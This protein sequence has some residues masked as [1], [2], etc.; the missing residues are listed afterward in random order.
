LLSD[1]VGNCLTTNLIIEKNA[2]NGFDASSVKDVLRDFFGCQNTY[3]LPF[4]E[5]EQTGHVDMYAAFTGPKTLILGEYMVEHDPENA[6]I[7]NEI[8]AVLLHDGFTVYRIHMPGN[9]D[10]A[11]RTYTNALAVGE[12]VLVPSYSDDTRFETEAIRIFRRAYPSRRVVLVNTTDVI[13][14]GGGI[15]CATMSTNMQ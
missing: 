9:W 6:A 1:G 2:H 10:G 15:H 3:I 5:G 7:L 12:V 14:Y 11:F 8:A 4:L 13:Q